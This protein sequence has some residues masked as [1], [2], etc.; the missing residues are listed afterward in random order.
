MFS[1]ISVRETLLRAQPICPCVLQGQLDGLIGVMMPIVNIILCAIL[2][3][4][5]LK[6]AFMFPI[7]SCFLEKLFESVKCCSL[8]ALY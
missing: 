6:F 3:I 5:R 1:G 7:S 8:L 4:L 2:A